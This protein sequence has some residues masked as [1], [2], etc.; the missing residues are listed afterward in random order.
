MK[1]SLSCL[2][3][4]LLL[5]SCGGGDDGAGPGNGGNNNNELPD[6][7][8]TAPGT[9]DGAPSVQTIGA[10]GGTITNAGAGFTIDIPAGA[11]ASDTEITVQ[12][13]TNTAWG[14]IGQGVRLTPDGL[15]F[16]QPVT[17]TFD[18]AP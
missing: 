12:P 5:V 2:I 8:A 7:V 15:T 14:G 3:A 4:A 9:P 17:L 1:R 16:T 13:I 11:L 18:I 10:G 6:P